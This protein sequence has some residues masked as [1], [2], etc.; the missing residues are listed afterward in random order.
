MARLLA[1]K[2]EMVLGAL[3]VL[4]H[5]TVRIVGLFALT[6]VWSVSLRSHTTMSPHDNSSVA[7]LAVGALATVAGSRLLAP[8]AAL[9]ASRRVAAEWWLVPVGRLMGAVMVLM[10]AV[11]IA[12]LAVAQTGVGSAALC[13]GATVY[14]ATLVSVTQALAPIVGASVAA[15]L[16]FLGVGLGALTPSTVGRILDAWP[17]V[18]RPIVLIL[19]FY[20]AQWRV[21]RILSGIAWPDLFIMT[22]WLTVGIIGAAWASHSKRPTNRRQAGSRND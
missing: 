14:V 3:L 2:A 6:M 21:D 15:G 8:G 20:P 19:H 18:Q 13:L 10:P 9:G 12:V 7:L 5:R 11:F 16:G 4:R 17:M 22:S 1:A